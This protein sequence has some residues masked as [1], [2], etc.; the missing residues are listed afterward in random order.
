[1]VA[2]ITMPSMAKREG[3]GSHNVQCRLTDQELEQLDREC[4]KQ[5][6]P[7]KR[8][9]LVSYIVREWLHQRREEAATGKGRQRAN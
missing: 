7:V 8:A 5:R 2:M 3:V 1:M 4:E 9:A 6:I